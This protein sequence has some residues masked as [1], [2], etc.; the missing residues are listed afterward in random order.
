[1]SQGATKIQKPKQCP[2]SDSA[3]CTVPTNISCC[4]IACP[5]WVKAK[6]GEFGAVIQSL[7]IQMEE[8][9][10]NSGVKA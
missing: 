4:R 3:Q 5:L 8:I 9:H 6:N 1:M 7:A 10:G 2:F